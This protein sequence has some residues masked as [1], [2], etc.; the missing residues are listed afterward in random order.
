MLWTR[1]KLLVW[2][3]SILDT[4]FA[5]FLQR[6]WMRPNLTLA[7][8]PM[9]ISFSM[10][11]SQQW[12]TGGPE[13]NLLSNASVIGWLCRGWPTYCHRSIG[14]SFSILWGHRLLGSHPHLVC[15]GT[16]TWKYVRAKCS[17][18]LRHRLW[19]PLR[20]LRFGMATWLEAWSES[21]FYHLGLCHSILL[22]QILT[23]KYYEKFSTCQCHQY[24]TG[25]FRCCGHS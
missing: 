9:M 1:N 24:R 13:M 16:L 23:W 19:L 14:A 10:L 2:S 17:L 11:V 12:R 18:R 8:C 20:L 7:G 5:W 3:A 21:S 25:L 6:T 4:V 15:G 22:L